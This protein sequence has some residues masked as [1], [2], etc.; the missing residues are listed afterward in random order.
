MYTPVETF[1]T[2]QA[3]W[4]PPAAVREARAKEIDSQRKPKS[5]AQFFREYRG[6][7]DCVLDLFR[8]QGYNAHFTIRRVDCAPL[9]ICVHGGIGENS[10][11]TDK[12]I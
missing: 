1:G 11:L 3:P 6:Y 8:T 2:G 5:W 12:K 7:A 9:L 10:P 4:R